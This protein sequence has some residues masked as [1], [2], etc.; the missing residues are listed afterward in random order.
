[1][2]QATA[3]MRQ[4][5]DWSAAMWAGVISGIIFLMVNL[6]LTAY[7]LGSPWIV[8]RVLASVVMG[9]RVL[10]PPAS[11]D[12]TIF[13]V[14][15]IVHLVLSVL[16]ACLLAIVIH[17]WGLIVGIVG[18]ALFGLALYGINF[19]SFSYFFPWFFPFKSWMMVVSHVVF[20]AAAGGIY[21]ALEVEEFV[22]VEK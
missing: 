6:L 15:L 14:A 19:Y 1:M 18:G 12:I 16:F 5:V 20:G 17:R 7:T 8:V 13:V 11:F 22:P 21:E 10:P 2:S 4:V 9:N 3:R